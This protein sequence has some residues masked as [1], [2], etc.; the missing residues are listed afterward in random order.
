MTEDNHYCDDYS[1]EHGVCGQCGGDCDQEHK[2][3]KGGA[4]AAMVSGVILKPEMNLAEK[5][6]EEV[7]VHLH[8]PNHGMYGTRKSIGIAIAA[9]IDICAKIAVTARKNGYGEWWNGYDCA[10]KEIAAR[11]RALTT[12]R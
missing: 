6:A 8:G 3:D 7:T 5:L 1:C 9:A 10:M 11:I 4:P 12:T 2:E